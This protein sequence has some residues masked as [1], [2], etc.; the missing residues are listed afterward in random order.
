MSNATQTLALIFAGTLALALATS[1]SWDTTSST[2]FQTELLAVDTSAVQAVRIDDPD[3]A[4]IRLERTSNGWVVSPADTSATYP[5][6]RQSVEQLLG[7]LPSLQVST[8]ATRQSGKHP[9]YGVDS[10]GTTV[11]ALGEGNEVL[12]ELIVGRTRIQRPQGGQGRSGMRQRMRRGTPITY[13]R[14]PDRP[15]VYSIDQ[16]LRSVTSRSA[17]NWRKKQIWSVDRANIQQVDFQYPADSSFT[18]SRVAHGDTSAASTAWVSGRDTLARS[19]VSSL[20]GTLSN[21]QADGFAETLQPQ[22]LGEAPYTIQLRLADGARRSLDLRPASTGQ[23]YLATAD[24]FPYVAELSTRSW[25]NSVLK[26]RS[27]FLQNE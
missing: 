16:S 12:G 13:V 6:S 14:S 19:K 21:P 20:L 17:E 27:A 24:G 23:Q 1:W 22:D 15:D 2:A 5:A 25:D 11:A 18:I 10:T 9:Q 8:V 3:R 7:T 4:T 26:G